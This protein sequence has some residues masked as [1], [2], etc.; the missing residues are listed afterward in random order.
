[1]GTHIQIYGDSSVK[2]GPPPVIP[3]Y[4]PLRRWFHQG[5]TQQTPATLLRAVLFFHAVTELVKS[6][7][8]K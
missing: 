6:R 7:R 8:M 1:M 2:W 5:L 4:S 3:L